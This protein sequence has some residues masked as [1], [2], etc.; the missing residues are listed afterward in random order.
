MGSSSCSEAFRLG[1]LATRKSSSS[2][3]APPLPPTEKT[4][5]KQEELGKDAGS[6]SSCPI[7]Y[8]A[9]S[10][11]FGGTGV[12]LSL[13]HCEHLVCQSCVRK[14][15]ESTSVWGRDL[16][17]VSD[18]FFYKCPLCRELGIVGKRELF[19]GQ[20]QDEERDQQDAEVQQHSSTFPSHINFTEVGRNTGRRRCCIVCTTRKNCQDL[21]AIFGAGIVGFSLPLFL[22]F[23]VDT[24]IAYSIASTSIMGLQRLRR[25]FHARGD[26]AVEFEP[27]S[28]V[29]AP[30]PAI[31]GVQ[32]QG[33]H[34]ESSLRFPQMMMA[35]LVRVSSSG[36]ICN[37]EESENDV[38]GTE[39]V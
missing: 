18:D 10:E 37:F 23:Q 25:F 29:Q 33:V 2:S 35:K 19:L 4:D 3:V 38:S 24:C 5:E 12:A 36:R 14:F 8:T 28:E 31:L 15:L 20:S 26:Q 16:W 9:F 13:G 11:K 34:D 17:V 6:S 30:F 22:G 32:A 1:R 27:T 39:S 21:T 7:C